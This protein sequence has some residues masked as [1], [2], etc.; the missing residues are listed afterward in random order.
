MLEVEKPVVDVEALVVNLAASPA[1]H[2]NVWPFAI[3]AIN[4]SPKLS[5]D[6]RPG[7]KV[8]SSADEAVP[9]VLDPQVSVPQP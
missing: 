6:Q 3:V 7:S 4:T 8:T 5:K 1:F 9:Q 2:V